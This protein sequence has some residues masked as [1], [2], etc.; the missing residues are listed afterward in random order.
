MPPYLS[1]HSPTSLE[2]HIGPPF[3]DGGSPLTSFLIEWD[4]SPTFDSSMLGDG[5]SLGSARANA[6]SQVCSSCVS[7]F[8]LSTN[9]FTYSGSEVTAKLLTPQRKIMVHFDD[10]GESYTFSVIATTPTTISVS[11]NHLRVLSLNS[12]RDQDDGAGSRLEL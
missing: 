4:P 10:D 6:A 11:N 3:Y 9:T 2:V 1:V 12:M 8:D 7:D 5:S